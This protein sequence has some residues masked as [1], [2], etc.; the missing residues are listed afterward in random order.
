M[1]AQSELELGK[2]YEGIR[3][4]KKWVGCATLDMRMMVRSAMRLV[5][6]SALHGNAEAQLQLG[7]LYHLGNQT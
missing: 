1:D 7:K 2:H 5:E 4:F 3:D 6:R